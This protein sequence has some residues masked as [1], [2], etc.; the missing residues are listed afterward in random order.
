M[1]AY[2]LH[3]LLFAVGALQ[4]LAMPTTNF[5]EVQL[6]DPRYIEGG[7]HLALPLFC[8]FLTSTSS[9]LFPRSYKI[10]C[11]RK[12][13]DLDLVKTE[14]SNAAKMAVGA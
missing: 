5:D 4:S 8:P 7:S 13:E 6:H 11:K 14:L 1:M 3:V 9:H 10:D 12:Q 2:R